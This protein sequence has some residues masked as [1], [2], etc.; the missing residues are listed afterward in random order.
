MPPARQLPPPS[1]FQASVPQVFNV[2]SSSRIEEV[3]QYEHSVK[4]IVFLSYDWHSFVIQ[5][6]N[7]HA[8]TQVYQQEPAWTHT[9]ASFSGA[10]SMTQ[11]SQRNQ[12]TNQSPFLYPDQRSMQST[13]HLGHPQSHG[14]GEYN[15]QSHRQRIHPAQPHQLANSFTSTQGVHGVQ[16]S[17]QGSQLRAQTQPEALSQAALSLQFHASAIGNT[18]SAAYR[19]AH[20]RH[21]GLSPWIDYFI[22]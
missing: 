22:K 4:I 17:P 2:S 9:A 12:K 15:R 16:L 11:S 1:S 21:N 5:S 8:L 18:N 14:P 19:P 7:P 10:S 20:V 6:S 13:V 3:S